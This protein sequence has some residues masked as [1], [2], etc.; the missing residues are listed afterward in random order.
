MH[1]IARLRTEIF[2]MPREEESV[3]SQALEHPFKQ[4]QKFKA[5]IREHLFTPKCLLTAG[6]RLGGFNLPYVLQSGKRVRICLFFFFHSSYQCDRS[7]E[8]TFSTLAG[9]FNRKLVC[10]LLHTTDFW[11]QLSQTRSISRD[12]NVL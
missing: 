10:S 7:D 6:I 4:N 12:V 2:K 11:T 1:T 8:N 9:D 3:L 5:L